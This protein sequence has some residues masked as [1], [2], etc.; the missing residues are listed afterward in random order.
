M[1]I[2]VR[3]NK[4]ESKT[5]MVDRETKA[6]QCQ[7]IK[8]N[9]L[10]RTKRR[11]IQAHNQSR[12]EKFGRSDVSNNALQ[13]TD[14]EQWRT[15]ATLGNAGQNTLVLLLPTKARDQGWT[16]TSSRSHHC[17]RN[18]FYTSLQYCAQIHSDASSIKKFQVQR[19]QWRK[20]GKN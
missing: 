15:P 7:T 3:C 4:E 20:N 13:N 17:K 9:I 6:R 2:Y 18:K 16:Q 11:R 1:E 8:R 12:S 10:Y 19:R 14:K 5:K